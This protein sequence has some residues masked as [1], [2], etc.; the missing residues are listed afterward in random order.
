MQPQ[1]LQYN[2]GEGVTAFSTTRNGGISTGAYAA[3]NITHYCGDD[4]QCVAENRRRLCA[5]LGIDCNSL[6]LP[7]QT[8]DTNC[9]VIDEEFFSLNMQERSARLEGVDAVM[10]N[11]PQVCIGVSTADCIP[12]LLYDAHKRVVAAIHAGW[13][14]TVAR[15]TE[16]A[17]TKMCE[18]YGCNAA[19]ICAVIGPGIS[20]DAFEVGD[21]VYDAFL[22]ASFPMEQIAKRYGNRWHID[23]WQ[24]N[25]LQ[26]L[27]CGIPE[28]SV[29][30]SGVCTYSMYN[31]FFS[32]RRLGIESGRI[33][34]GIMLETV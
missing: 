18:V 31:K 14:G 12:V 23:L 17:F 4:G 22:A 16:T 2:M 1:L 24:A 8:H 6:I 15:I 27:S 21:E 11:I 7:R 20:L 26:L 30:I 5:L 34:N 29:T 13:R 9:E 10:T 25:R 3:L 19:D 32:A 28:Q 33:F